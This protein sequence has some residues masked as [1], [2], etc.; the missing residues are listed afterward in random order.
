METTTDKKQGM[1]L[2][3]LEHPNAASKSPQEPKSKPLVTSPSGAGAGSPS[4]G[5]VLGPDGEAARLER[6]A[7]GAWTGAQTLGR[8]IGERAEEAFSDFT[9][10]AGGFVKR[11]PMTAALCSLGVG[12]LV[13]L[14]VG[15]AIARD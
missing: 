1:P 14:I 10:G 8:E 7:K 6:E 12:V 5:T 9:T 13:G 11:E 2:G 3:G 15:I 4:G